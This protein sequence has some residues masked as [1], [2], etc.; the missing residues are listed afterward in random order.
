MSAHYTHM[1]AHNACV[2]THE[3]P[4]PMVRVYDPS[5]GVVPY[6]TGG[7][8]LKG[9]KLRTKDWPSLRLVLARLLHTTDLPSSSNRPS[10]FGAVPARECIMHIHALERIMYVHVHTRVSRCTHVVALRAPIMCAH[11]KHGSCGSIRSGTSFLT[12]PTRLRV[13]DPQCGNPEV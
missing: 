4:T 6:K 1:L 3:G 8:P 2:C 5:S 12:S 13:Y 10:T 9:S 7:R 11:N